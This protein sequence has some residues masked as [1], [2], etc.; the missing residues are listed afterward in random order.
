M[1][2]PPQRGR[3]A[4]WRPRPRSPRGR[5]GRAAP[6]RG[7]RR[8]AARPAAGCCPARRASRTRPARRCPPVA[9]AICRAPPGTVRTAETRP[10]RRPPGW[11]VLPAGGRATPAA[12]ARTRRS[13]CRR[14]ASRGRR[15]RP[16]LQVPPR[17]PS[18]WAPQKPCQ[19]GLGASPRRQLPHHRPHPEVPGLPGLE[20]GLQIAPRSLEPSFEAADAAPQDEESG[21]KERGFGPTVRPTPSRPRRG[22]SCSPVRG[23][24]RHRPCRRAS[25]PCRYCP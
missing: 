24:S 7:R 9:G 14:R 12:A 8:G 20:G 13:A 21:G 1:R 22:S 5:A 11:R 2:P 15:P 17:W 6:R 23:P 19:P 18:R 3:R 4:R 16:R 25:P 10:G